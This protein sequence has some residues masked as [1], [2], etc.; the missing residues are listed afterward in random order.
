MD[1]QTFDY[2]AARP[3]FEISCF[4]ELSGSGIYRSEIGDLNAETCYDR[5]SD[6]LSDESRSAESRTHS[7]D[8]SNVEIEL[9]EW[10][11]GRAF[12]NIRSDIFVWPGAIDPLVNCFMDFLASH[13]SEKDYEGLST[14]LSYDDGDAL[15]DHQVTNGFAATLTWRFVRDPEL[16]A[17]DLHRMWHIL[18]GTFPHLPVEL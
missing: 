13:E 11:T 6:D 3:W 14:V 10:I 9:I 12:S 8:R 7:F 18:Y 5:D 16:Q 17:G 15:L 1:Q 4:N 2:A